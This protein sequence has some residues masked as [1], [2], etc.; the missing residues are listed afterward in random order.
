MKPITVTSN[1]FD[2]SSNLSQ[3]EGGHINFSD[4]LSR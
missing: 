3:M 4:F 1:P 2:N